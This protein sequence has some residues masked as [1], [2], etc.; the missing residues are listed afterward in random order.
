MNCK[1]NNTKATFSVADFNT[2]AFTAVKY[3][4][5]AVVKPAKGHSASVSRKGVFSIEV[6]ITTGSDKVFSI[7]LADLDKVTLHA[8]CEQALRAALTR[9]VTIK[10]L[11]DLYVGA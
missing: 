5:L 3:N 8:K 11:V 2:S 1:I 4:D 7:E 9:K 6:G 10:Q